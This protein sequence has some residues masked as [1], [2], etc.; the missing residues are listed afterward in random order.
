MH[1]KL[2][3]KQAILR[4]CHPELAAPFSLQE[5]QDRLDRVRERMAQEN[6]DLLYLSAPESVCYV[7]GYAASWYA[8][9]GN[10]DWLPISGIAIHV[11]HDRF[12]LFEASDELILARNTSVA[13]DIRVI[14][15]SNGENVVAALKGEGWLGGTA[16]LELWSYRPN[17]AVSDLFRGLLER[18]GCTVVD[19][20]DVVRDVRAVK[21]PQ[22]LS[23]IETA[24][25]IADI[26]M[27][28]AIDHARPGMT[29]IE[30]HAEVLYAMA[31]AGGELN[32][33]PG[34]VNSGPRTCSHGLTSRRRIMPGDLVTLDICG[35][36]NRYHANV[37]R[38]LSM[39][40][41]SPAVAK[42]IELS[43]KSVDV[44]RSTIRPYLPVADLNK[45]MKDYFVNVGIWEDR[46]WVGGYEFGIAFAP[47][48][49]GAFV[50]DPD[51][52]PG[53]RVFRPGEV[54]NFESMFYLPENAGVS[55]L[56]NSI[57]YKQTEAKLLSEIPSELVEIE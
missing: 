51:D 2:S 31:K 22:E 42:Q 45:V 21:S 44:L 39:G 8:S 33:I 5:Y 16:G 24:A 30:V 35:V 25:R 53:D 23:C 57:M 11:D 34:L 56:I 17:P 32:A 38:T 55:W 29:E 48:W 10:K 54:V 6:I 50:F 12:I 7:S 20:T 47:D 43:S 28:A 36:Y 18:E 1:E 14:P 52:D 41:P 26:G 27:Q 46:W 15:R 9:N 4:D 49:V 40:R 37:S 13:T 3:N 19:G